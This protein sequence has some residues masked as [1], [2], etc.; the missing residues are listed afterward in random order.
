MVAPGGGYGGAIVDTALPAI[1][2]GWNAAAERGHASIGC[3]AAATWAPPHAF[4][5][6]AAG[7][8]MAH[9]APLGPRLVCVFLLGMLLFSFPLLSLF[10]RVDTVFRIPIL[11]AYLFAAWALVIALLALAVERR[12]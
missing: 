12:R 8:S 6:E 10:N 9:R 4:R 2:I 1:C 11:F 3:R 5:N 7:G